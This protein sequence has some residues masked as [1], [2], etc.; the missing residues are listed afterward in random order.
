[1][2]VK[3]HCDGPDC[4]AVMTRDAARIALEI[5]AADAPNAQTD[6]TY[7]TLPLIASFGFTGDH[8]FCS[9]PCLAAW[10]MARHDGEQD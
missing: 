10:A 9:S 5:V 3:Y 4:I 7:D 2:T 8:H 6:E 1:M